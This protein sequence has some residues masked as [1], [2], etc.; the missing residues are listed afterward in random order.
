LDLPKIIGKNDTAR[1]LVS[2]EGIPRLLP[3]L[4]K[5]DHF[6]IALNHPAVLIFLENKVVE[7]KP[8]DGDTFEINQPN[9]SPSSVLLRSRSGTVRRRAATR[10]ASSR[11]M[12]V[13][14]DQRDVFLL[15][16]K[17]QRNR[18]ASFQSVPLQVGLCFVSDTLSHT[19][20]RILLHIVNPDVD[21]KGA[22]MCFASVGPCQCIHGWATT[23]WIT[24]FV[25]V[26]IIL[27]VAH[28]MLTEVHGKFSFSGS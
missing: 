12:Q 13:S 2:S 21:V 22:Q 11:S 25:N 24:V 15:H 18:G 20:L 7:L 3:R 8:D 16:G 14:S 19:V 5:T 9:R 6:A 1:T 10:K 23:Y 26:E 27:V 4:V 28:G 17:R